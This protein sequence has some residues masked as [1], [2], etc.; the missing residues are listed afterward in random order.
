MVAR[1]GFCC[2]WVS[3]TGNTKEEKSLNQVDVTISRLARLTVDER[4]R[5]LTT[6][7]SHNLN[8]LLLLVGKVSSMDPGR[9]MLRIS[10]DILPCFSHELVEDVYQRKHYSQMLE[11]TF[12]KI[13]EIAKATGTR[14]VFHPDHFVRL[15]SH[16]DVIT[17]RAVDTLEFHT[18]LYRIMGMT[19][20][21]HDY[22]A[23]VNIHVGGRDGGLEQ[24]K[25]GFNKLSIEAKR[26][27]TLENDEFS[28]G[29][30]DVCYLAELCPIVTDIYHEWVFTRG[31]FIQ[32]EDQRI[33][34]IIIPSWRGTTPLGHFSQ[35]KEGLFAA[36]SD[37]LLDFS[38]LSTNGISALKARSHSYDC[39][40]DHMNEWAATHLSWMDIEV[41]AKGKNLA[42]DTFERFVKSRLV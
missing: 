3:P 17:K 28:F 10:S 18:E 30:S 34:D 9:R 25:K 27:L 5:L 33:T 14:L 35:P 15:N 20:G 38:Y 19:S 13:G 39:W 40:N 42:A 29:L 6:K 31:E 23:V 32:P 4:D 26:V 16:D 22:G 2:K 41:E 7:V 37:D 1:I 8:A 24:F 21:F 11:T 12:S 36:R